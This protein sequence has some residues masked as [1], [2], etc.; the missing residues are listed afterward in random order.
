MSIDDV[1][2]NDAFVRRGVDTPLPPP[3]SETGFIGWAHKSLFSGWF[4]TILTFIG[5]YVAYALFWPLIEFAF[6]NAVW[7]GEDRNAC[8]GQSGAC[9]RTS[10]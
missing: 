8:I 3:T 6:I 1:H 9:W 7:S 5:A 4:N 2:T 10:Y